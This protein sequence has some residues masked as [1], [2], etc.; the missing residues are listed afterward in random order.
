MGNPL[1]LI[2]AVQIIASVFGKRVKDKVESLPMQENLKYKSD[3]YS[4]FYD[5]SS[6]RHLHYIMIESLNKPETDPVLVFFNGGPGAASTSLAFN[7]MGP[8][9][10]Y[11][12]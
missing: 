11:D 2:I 5:V 1:K 9:Y 12:G 6:N 8:T 3:W 7:G 4:G 10:F